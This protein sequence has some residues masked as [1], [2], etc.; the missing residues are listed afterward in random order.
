MGV[1]SFIFLYF[2]TW[3]EGKDLVMKKL[4]LILSLFIATSIYPDSEN[5][6]VTELVGSWST[7]CRN[8]GNIT[9]SFS[10]DGK[11]TRSK[12][13]YYTAFCLLK[14]EHE[15]SFF[16][17]KIG[18]VTNKEKAIRELDIFVTREVEY[19]NY[20][21]KSGC[22]S[23]K[24]VDKKYY[25]I[26]QIDKNGNLYFGKGRGATQVERSKKIRDEFLS[27]WGLST[28]H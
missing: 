10:T 18:K 15:T 3:Y 6:P 1:L 19:E 8:E 14:K 2:G 24:K 22:K 7:K 13:R 4:L 11:G 26:F 17:Y 25:T 28:T 5:K 16:T 12:N 20:I 9:I 23:D 21:K 27:R